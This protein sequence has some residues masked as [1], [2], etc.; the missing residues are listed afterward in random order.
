MASDKSK[1]VLRL[2]SSEHLAKLKK[3]TEERIP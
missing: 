1:Q 3:Q 2:I